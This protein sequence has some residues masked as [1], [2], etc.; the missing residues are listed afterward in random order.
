[1]D[2]V[3][4]AVNVG[5]SV[6]RVGS[7]AQIAAMKKIAG[8]LKLELAQYREVKDF[9]KFGSDLDEQTL[10][11]I[12]R[13]K[14]LTVLLMQKRFSPVQIEKQVLG[15]YAALNGYL[16]EYEGNYKKVETFINSL[17]EYAVNSNLFKPH[18]YLLRFESYFEEFK[19][20]FLSILVE[21]YKNYVYKIENQR[22]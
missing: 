14:L 18:M 8:P 15:L 9:V 19:L 21:F 11:L 6:S 12:K 4:P 17:Y 16:D 20:D 3:L 1:I 5:L 10:N 2:G 7:A 22:G 13:G